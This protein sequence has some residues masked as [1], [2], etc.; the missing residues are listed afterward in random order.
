MVE[1]DNHRQTG[2]PEWGNPTV[3]DIQ[4]QL[5]LDTKDSLHQVVEVGS[6]HQVVHRTE[7]SS[8]Q[9]ADQSTN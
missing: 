4:D 8:F 7:D 1:V 9:T 6:H 5:G 3:V 2:N